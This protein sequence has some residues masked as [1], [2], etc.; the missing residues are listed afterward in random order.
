[1]N[2]YPAALAEAKSPQKNSDG[3]TTYYVEVGYSQGQADLESF[4]PSTL[5]VHP[6]DTIVWT[7]SQRDIAPH[8][9]TFLN[10]AEEPPLVVPKPQQSGPPLLTLNP[11]VAAPQNAGKPLTTTG[12]YSSGIIDPHAPGPHSIHLK[13]V[14]S[15]EPFPTS[16]CY[17]KKVG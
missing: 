13:S 5:N 2:M 11:E 17:M 1:M 16:A 15:V 9:I 8:T 10:G 14:M 12:V 6:G 4:F 3:T 7:F